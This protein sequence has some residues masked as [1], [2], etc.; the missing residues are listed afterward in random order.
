MTAGAMLAGPVSRV[1][2]LRGIMLSLV[3]IAALLFAF[4]PA[5]QASQALALVAVFL[6]G[7]LPSVMVPMLQTRLMDVAHEGQGLA[8]ALNHSTLNIA[9]ALGA[10]L[11]SLVLAAGLGYEWPSRVGGILAVLGLGVAAWSAA[12]ERRHA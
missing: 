11:G 6:L 8:A 10:W 7:L 3:V 12:L 1:G 4:G 2:L 9:N 5:V